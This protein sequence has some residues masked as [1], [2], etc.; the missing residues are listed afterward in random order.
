VAA[1]SNRCAAGVRCR[2]E[3]FLAKPIDV[4][5]IEEVITALI[6]EGLAALSK[7]RRISLHAVALGS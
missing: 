7:L 4:G 3:G 6:G 5:T 1:C 2:F